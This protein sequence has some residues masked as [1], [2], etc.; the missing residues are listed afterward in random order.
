MEIDTSPEKEK[1]TWVPFPAHFL[2]LSPV[3]KVWAATMCENC[4]GNPDIFLQREDL[5]LPELEKGVLV[6]PLP[7]KLDR[8]ERAPVAGGFF[9]PFLSKAA[10]NATL[11]PAYND[12]TCGAPLDRVPVG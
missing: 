12:L 5:L 8:S 3:H 10:G 9:R 6:D 2:E 4:H 1:I 11:I 7:A